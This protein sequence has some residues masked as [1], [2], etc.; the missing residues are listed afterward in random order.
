MVRE[1]G[2]PWARRLSMV[3]EKV[4]IGS[5]PDRAFYHVE[6]GQEDEQAERLATSLAAKPPLAMRSI[7]SVFR[8]ITKEDNLATEDDALCF[9]QTIASEDFV[10]ALAAFFEKRKGQYKNK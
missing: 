5:L 10:E 2:L 3:G 9:A 7:K 1:Y 8:E 4:R 6:S